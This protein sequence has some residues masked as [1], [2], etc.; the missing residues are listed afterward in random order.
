MFSVHY[1]GGASN[2]ISKLGSPTSLQSGVAWG[3]VPRP[4]PTHLP[5]YQCIC[6]QESESSQDDKVYP[7]KAKH[8]QNAMETLESNRLT[9]KNV[10]NEIFLLQWVCTVH[11][12]E[13]LLG[14][15]FA[16]VVQYSTVQTLLSLSDQ[17]KTFSP[18]GF[19]V[20]FCPT[21]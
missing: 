5:T 7:K 16:P 14:S 18:L 13:L 21:L 4:H 2:N 8:T 17:S 15:S 12:T 10:D 1:L 9:S 3:C 6:E 20:H 11:Y 19:T